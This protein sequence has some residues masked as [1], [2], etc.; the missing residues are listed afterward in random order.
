MNILDAYVKE[1]GYF[2]VVFSSVDEELLS[3]IVVN[4]AKDFKAEVINI[5]SIMQNIDDLDE[6]R[7]LD[8]FKVKNKVRFV[9]TSIFPSGFI[10]KPIMTSYHINISLNDKTKIE[11]GI[12]MRLSELEA[13]YKDKTFVNK[14]LNL[15]KFNSKYELE[16]KIYDML[17]ERINLKLDKG[18]YKKKLDEEKYGTEKYIRK[19]YDQDEKEKYLE[20]KNKYIDRDI[21]ESTEED[22]LLDDELSEKSLNETSERDSSSSEYTDNSNSE[23]ESSEFVKPNN[24]STDNSSEYVETSDVRSESLEESES[25]SLEESESESLDESEFYDDSSILDNEVMEGG[26]IEG[27][28][29]IKGKYIDGKRVIKRWIRI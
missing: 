6:N 22:S 10:K 2:T 14:Y 1:Y 24:N 8:L 26:T 15:S 3:E 23:S 13:K 28:R 20:E 27:V 25:E 29:S 19:P 16:S 17:I 5:F 12:N 11:K 7:L 9:I 21:M 4:L 18:T